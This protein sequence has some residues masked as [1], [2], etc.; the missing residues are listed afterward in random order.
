MFTFT[1][2][3]AAVVA[4]FALPAAAHAAA[5]E[6][7]ITSAPPQF[8]NET[9]ATFSFASTDNGDGFQCKLD[10]T[11]SFS[12]CPSP[13]TTPVLSEGTHTLEVRAADPPGPDREFE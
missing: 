3:L 10:S 5:G 8:T 7:S 2:R 11:R 1:A 13:Y 6:S 4:L 12:D 9:Q